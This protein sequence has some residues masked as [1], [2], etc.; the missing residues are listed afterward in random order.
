MQPRDLSDHAVYVPGEGTEEVARDLGLDPE[1]LIALSSNENPFGPSPKAVEAIHDAAPEAS[2]YPKAAHT[3]L[4]AKIADSW[5]LDDEQIWLTPGADGGID[6]LSRAMLDPGDSVLCPEPGFSYYPMSTQYHHG[7]PRSYPV[8]KDDT[9][10]LDAETVLD[11]YDDDRMIY[12]TSPHNPTGRTVPLSTVVEIA[13]RTGEETLVVVDEAYGEYAAVDSART[14]LDDRDDVAALRTFSKA[15]GLAGLRLGY[16]MVPKSWADAYGR[17]NTPF[18]VNELA[19]RAGLAAID[20]DEHVEQTVDRAEWAREYIREHAAAPSWESEGNFVLLD[21]GDASAVASAMKREG[22]I[23]RDCSSFG[24]P[25]CVRITC[26]QKAET[27]R[28]VEVLNDVLAAA[29]HAT[30]ADRGD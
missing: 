2:G 20:D 27:K 22:I 5:G 7:V 1:E 18:A 4:T 30:P 25:G 3:D 29:D 24:L 19:C 28:A 8:R 15:Y 10:D 9:F 26:G 12:L 17:V 11:A 16:V 14:L 21:V 23:V 6:C 13:D